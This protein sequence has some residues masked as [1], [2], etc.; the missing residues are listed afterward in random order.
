MRSAKVTA[1][2]FSAGFHRMVHR[3]CPVP[4]SGLIRRPAGDRSQGRGACEYGRQRHDQHRGQLVA[5]TPPPAWVI[6]RGQHVPDRHWK[7][8]RHGRQAPI[9]IPLPVVPARLDTH[10]VCRPDATP[11]ERHE[12]ALPPPHRD[13]SGPGQR[14]Q[15][16]T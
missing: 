13:V 12:Q 15:R 10:P 2:A 1:K 11:P 8:D 14:H 9:T 4:S 5:T 16:K 7:I 6:D 3:A